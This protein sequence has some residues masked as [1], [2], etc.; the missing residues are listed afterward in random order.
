MCETY[1]QYSL[2]QLLDKKSRRL[3]N[4]YGSKCDHDS[5]NVI[6]RLYDNNEGLTDAL[7]HDGVLALL[8]PRYWKLAREHRRINREFRKKF[9]KYVKYT[10]RKPIYKSV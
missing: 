9:R 3:V 5:Y 10:G 2:Y 7:T 4:R 8:T 6:E 1:I